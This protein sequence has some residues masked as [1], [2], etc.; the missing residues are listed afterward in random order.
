MRAVRRLVWLAVAA[1]ILFGAAYL[2][3]P[4]LA[5]R[6]LQAAARS[7]DSIQ[8]ERVIDFPSVRGGLKTQLRAL[9]A[10]RIHA[11]PALRNNPFAGMGLTLLP[12]L[13]DQ[14][15]DA[16]LTPQSIAVM[17][18][19]GRTPA[20]EKEALLLSKPVLLE[21]HYA[22]VNLNQVRVTA[23]GRDHPN[24]PL[25]FVLQRRGLFHWVLVRID[26]PAKA[27]Q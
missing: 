15:A 11:D 16:Y 10:A 17:V 23:A 1:A 14:M 20:R 8:M 7:G 21:T 18:A 25:D 27:L 13:V 24:L 6:S 12:R 9:F 3:S 2:G 26:L 4:F 5:W 19:Q 22:Y